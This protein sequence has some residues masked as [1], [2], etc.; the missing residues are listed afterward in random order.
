[1]E[2]IQFIELNAATVFLLI[3]IGFIAGMVPVSS[4]RAA[5]VLTPT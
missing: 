2:A 1:M 4:A 3:L 5:L